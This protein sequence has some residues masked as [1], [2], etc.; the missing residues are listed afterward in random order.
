MGGKRASVPAEETSMYKSW[1][2]NTFLYQ[3]YLI[4]W[5]EDRLAYVGPVYRR[6]WCLSVGEK[7]NESC[8]LYK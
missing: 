4:N 5:F 1:K 8:S 2:R 7:R 3:Y 6:D